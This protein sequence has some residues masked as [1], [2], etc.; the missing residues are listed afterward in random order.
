[1]R[2]VITDSAI[3]TI[4]TARPGAGIDKKSLA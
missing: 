2:R 4:A 3:C 1:M